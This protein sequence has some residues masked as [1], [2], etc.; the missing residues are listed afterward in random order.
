MLV[1]SVASLESFEMVQIVYNKIIHHLVRAVVVVVVLPRP[2]LTSQGTSSVPVV[3]V[4]NKTDLRPEQ[5]R[6][7]A[8]D[9]QRVQREVNCAWTEAS[10]RYNENVELAFE[11]LIGEIEKARSPD[12]GAAKSSCVLM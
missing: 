1:Y 7:K 10:A 9:G 6:V 8:E 3:M 4:G 2:L 11:L 12:A 5:R